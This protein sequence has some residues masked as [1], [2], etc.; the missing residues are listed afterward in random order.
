M[1]RAAAGDRAAWRDLYARYRD[2][3]FR[4]A[5]RFTGNEADAR[6]VTQ[7]VFV[8]LFSRAREFQPQGKLT[9][10][11]WRVVANRCLN[12]RARARARLEDPADERLLALPAPAEQAPDQEA[13]R[14]QTQD[15][16]RQAILA[17]PERQR[18][19]VVL[20]RFEGLSYEGIADALDCSVSSV[21]SLLFRARAN[22]AKSLAQA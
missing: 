11:L 9:T 19:A 20:H 1:S 16:V 7:D 17:L 18:L 3:A 6:D 8:A 5:L 22:L 2:F 14:R 10:Y 4:A 13:E 12:E 15:A 21:E